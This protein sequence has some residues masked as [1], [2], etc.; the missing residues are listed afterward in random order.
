MAELMDHY[1]PFD[2]GAGSAVT[3]QTWRQFMRH[4]RPSGVLVADD[5]DGTE[6]A[7]TAGASGLTVDV[8]PGPCWIRGTYGASTDTKTLTLEAADPA[9]DRWDRIVARAD[10]TADSIDLAVL[11]GP[12]PQPYTNAVTNPSFTMDLDGWELREDISSTVTLTRVTGLS[13][14]GTSTDTAARLTNTDSVDRNAAAA[15]NPLLYAPPAGHT[16]ELQAQVRRTV[17]GTL[18]GWWIDYYDEGLNLI[19]S[20]S[21]QVDTGS[22]GAWAALSETGTVPTAAAYMRAV[23]GREPVGPDGTVDFTDVVLKGQGDQPPGTPALANDDTVEEVP[24]GLVHVAAAATSL[25]EADITDERTRYGYGVY[26]TWTPPLWAEGTPFGRRQELEVDLGDGG[27]KDCWY[28]R[29]GNIL[30]IDYRF[31]WGSNWFTPNGRIYTQLPPG[32]VSA[33]EGSH[34]LV[35]HLWTTQGGNMDW[36]GTTFAPPG[37]MHLWPFFPLS[38]SDCRI[39]WY[40]VNDGGGAGSGTPSIPGDYP[41]G[42]HLT[43]TGMVEVREQPLTGLEPPP[44]PPPYNTAEGSDGSGSEPPPVQRYTTEWISN[45]SITYDSFGS[46]TGYMY[47]GRHSAGAGGYE[48]SKFWFD[49]T[50]IRNTLAGSSIVKVELF[51]KNVH[52]YYSSGIWAMIGTVLETDETQAS[53]T[54]GGWDRYP[55]V[56]IDKYEGKWI[57]LPN[58]LGEEFRDASTSGITL[59][60]PFTGGLAEYGYFDGAN[61]LLKPTLR[62]T[63]DK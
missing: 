1:A 34:R 57:T 45:N 59:G 9:D 46:A 47:Q 23:V 2:A 16:V 53:P 60:S 50:S 40:T 36:P 37:S 14:P 21:G 24:L 42:G 52:S 58:S 6:L 56:H 51:L 55:R 15:T 25:T 41:E 28:L 61:N 11:T 54:S 20:E 19:S 35:S 43:I 39:S 5:A 30:F 48:Y 33:H 44:G 38:Q 49:H 17:V 10:F 29:L 22:T 63:Y 7:V 26:G 31:K 12:A 18:V 4:V 3:G 27:A 13:I 32:L 8:A 62:V